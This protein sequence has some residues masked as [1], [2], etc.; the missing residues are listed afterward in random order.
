M[1]GLHYER[2]T[3]RQPERWLYVLHGIFGAG[4]N[5]GSIIRRVVRE[6]PEWGALLIDLRQ[7]GHSQGFPG[8]HTVSAAA[9]DLLSLGDV[10]PPGAVLGH[11][12]GGKVAL[13]L[14][15]LEPA[16]STLRQLWIIDS[17]PDAREPTGSAWQMLELLQ[18][19]PDHF[20]SRQELIDRLVASRVSPPIAQWM[21]TNLHH[22]E[23][24]Y[25]WRFDRAAMEALLRSFFDTDAWSV[26]EQSDAQL[27]I[28]FVRATRSS[29]MDAAAVARVQAAAAH[30]HVHLHDVAGGHWLNA[31]NPDKIVSLLVENLP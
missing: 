28:H 18:Q 14:A 9:Q 8:P 31:D 2:V 23:H 1:A 20:S 11:S 19:L 22:V 10:A 13:L 24:E 4:R 16:R 5:W 15:G 21:A 27:D 12:F 25:R 7:H 3:E 17:T 6:R 29:V 30:G 26:V